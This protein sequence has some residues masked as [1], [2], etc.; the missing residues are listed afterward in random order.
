[1]ALFYFSKLDSE[2]CNIVYLGLC[3]TVLFSAEF[4]AISIQKTLVSSIHDEKPSFKVEGYFVHGLIYSTFVTA[5]WFAPSVVHIT[6]PRLAMII[7]CV[8]YIFHLVSYGAEEPWLIYCSAIINGVTASVMWTA[9]GKYLVLN[10]T[11]STLP[12][13]IGI[14]WFLF[15]IS[16]IYGNVVLYYRLEGKM[17]LDCKTRQIL[18]YAMNGMAVVS[19]FMFL[20]LQN[21]VKQNMNRRNLQEDSG[22]IQALKTTWTLFLSK[23]MFILALTFCYAGLQQTFSFGVHST[24]I[25]FTLRFGKNA[26]QCLALSGIF[27][28]AGEILGGAV[29]ILLSEFINRSRSKVMKLNLT[30]QLLVYLATFINLPNDASHE[31]TYAC[32]YINSCIYLAIMCSLLLGLTDSSI[33]AQIYALLSTMHPDKSA[34]TTALYKSIKGVFIALSYFLSSHIGLHTHL[35]MLVPVSIIS[36]AAFCYVD[37]DFSQTISEENEEHDAGEEMSETK[38]KH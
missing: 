12:R 28:G 9:Q 36:T 31:N 15:C 1:M 20:L 3:F 8:G 22:A 23:Y 7:A 35:A 10:S 24:S 29:Q 5:L 25:G 33:N 13:N 27:I 17:L 2:L 26:K 34:Q 19:L 37:K 4:A 6:G 38:V 32:A 14:F 21:P 18:V 11:A 30:I 16:E